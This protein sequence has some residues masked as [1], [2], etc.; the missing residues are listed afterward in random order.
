MTVYLI[1]PFILVCSGVALL[2]FIT[3][4]RRRGPF[5]FVLR[6]LHAPNRSS[7]IQIGRS[8]YAVSGALALFGVGAS[9]WPLLV[10]PFT[11]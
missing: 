4:S 8:L 9:L 1:V 10:L 2:G 5:A 11:L 3:A 7:Y 6:K